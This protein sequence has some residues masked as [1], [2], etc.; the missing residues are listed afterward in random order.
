MQSRSQHVLPNICVLCQKEKTITCRIIR[1]RK[2]EHLVKCSTIDAVNLKQAAED[3]KNET[4][5]MQIKDKDCVAIEVRYHNSCYKDYTRY[6]TKPQSDDTSKNDTSYSVA[7]E[8]FREK[9]K[10]SIIENKDI[11]RLKTLNDMFIK[12]VKL[13]HGKEADSY[14]TGNLK[15]RLMKTFPQLCFITPRMRSQSEIVYVNDI[16]TAALVEEKELLQDAMQITADREEDSTNEIVKAPTPSKQSNIFDAQTN[17]LK[18]SYMTAFKLRNIINDV[19]P[20]MP[21]PPTSEH[22]NKKPLQKH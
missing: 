15:T 13:T 5:L 10:S 6:L 17:E 4:L 18:D 14:K 1:K 16:S 9:V 3:N 7:F 11:T 19:K 22:R 8:V 2:K 21:W 20:T 12:Q